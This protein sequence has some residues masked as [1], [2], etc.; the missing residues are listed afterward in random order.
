MKRLIL[1]PAALAMLIFASCSN[2]DVPAP[3]VGGDGTVTFTATLPA[4]VLSR[5]GEGDVMKQLHYAVYDATTGARIFASDVEGDPQASNATTEFKLALDLVKGKTY[6]F[7]FWAD[8]AT[9]SPYTFSSKDKSVSVSYASAKSND[10]TRDAFFQAIKGLE[11]KGAMTQPVELRRPLSQINFGTDDVAKAEAASTVV[12]S[13]EVKVEGAYTSLN[14]LSGIASTPTTAVFTASGLP[15]G[16][17]FPVEETSYEYVAMA[18]V[19]TGIEL[20]DPDPATAD[21]Q[22]AKR[23]LFN[24][25][26]KFT[27]TDNQTATVEVPNAPVQRDYRTNIYGSLITA[28]INVNIEVKPGFNNEPGHNR[29]VFEAWD[30]T[31][32]SLPTVDATNRTVAVNAPSDLIGLAQMV[33]G[34]DGQTAQT[35]DGYTVTLAGD[36]DFGGHE[37]PMIAQGAT[38]SGANGNGAS[39]AGILDGKGATISN[40]TIASTAA[41]NTA[42]GFIASLKGENAA[43]RNITFKD[44]NI[45]STT[46]EQTA[47][48]GLLSGGAKVENVHVISGTIKG[49][50]ATAG[51]VGRILSKGV[52]ENCSN[53]ADIEASAHNVGG[54]VG[55]AY[56]R[57]NGMEIKNCTNSGNITGAT[58]GVG[59][60]VGL[61]CGDISGCR[62]SGTVTGA[63]TSVGGV[64]GEQ[65]NIGHISDCHNTGAVTLTTNA[66]GAGGVV[67]W[68]R[69]SGSSSNYDKAVI[70]VDGCTNSAP[71]L[72]GHCVAGIAGMIYGYGDVRHC[73]NTAPS[74]ASNCSGFVSG[75]ANQQSDAGS[76]LPDLDFSVKIIGNTSTTT[77]EQMT[78]G[79]LKGLFIYINDP[80][81][82]I[83]Q[84]NSTTL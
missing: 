32:V 8:A 9:G 23:E 27:F 48:V 82:V 24:T 84:D 29:P 18:Y 80:S 10:D 30:G 44:V 66:Y 62:N 47:I 3:P 78:T 39:F 28:A 35:F 5:Y 76:K 74:L 40:F 83:E 13:T 52:V 79:N 16:E 17:T 33:N 34:T 31:T 2:E 12:A 73:V 61:N 68:I 81:A 51:I 41:A 64:I 67:G 70:S 77:L 63:G 50:E 43:L 22:N 53:A 65:Q 54:I 14:L 71:V 26:L 19:L 75:I 25:S 46:A 42:S 37:I 15:E 38:R 55:A 58:A 21:V 69:Y 36:L 56:Y 20:E 11:V 4:E 49:T 7:I 57:N 45:S 1:A 59:G 6:D 72:G 60:I